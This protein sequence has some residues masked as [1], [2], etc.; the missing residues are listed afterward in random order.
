[1]RGEVVSF[2]NGGRVM[3]ASTINYLCNGVCTHD[4]KAGKKCLVRIVGPVD[5][6]RCRA[7]WACT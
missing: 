1:M 4:A 5:F 6:V 2:M 3:K 7:V